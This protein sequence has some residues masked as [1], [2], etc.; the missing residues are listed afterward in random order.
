MVR[1]LN[2]RRFVGSVVAGA[3]AAGLLKPALAQR[4]GTSSTTD[5]STDQPLTDQPLTAQPLTDRI[6]MIQ[7]AGTNLVALAGPNGIA[8][9]DGG[10][11]ART[12]EVLE[13]VAVLG[14]SSRIEVL[15]NSNWRAEHTGLNAN[16]NA[17]GGQSIAHVNTWLW[18]PPR[19]LVV[20]SAMLQLLCRRADAGSTPRTGMCPI[21]MGRLARGLQG[22]SQGLK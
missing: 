7:G 2:R 10:L 1:T 14:D 3:A 11:P 15:F 4:Y 16:V 5:P 12:A 22:R 21:T 8:L 18:M 13:F 19:T 6:T 9:V 17:I 20:T